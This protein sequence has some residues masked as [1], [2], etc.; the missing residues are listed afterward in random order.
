MKYTYKDQTVKAPSRRKAIAKLSGDKIIP[1]D[2]K[3]MP[4]YE[5]YL[6]AVK[7]AFGKDTHGRPKKS[8]TVKSI[9]T[10]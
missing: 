6:G 7:A 8:P 4:K 5:K 2:W 1:R 9:R 3:K 10:E